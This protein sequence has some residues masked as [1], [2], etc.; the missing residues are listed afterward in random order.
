VLTF[1]KSNLLVGRDVR[2]RDS[3][4]V[5]VTDWLE[6]DPITKRKK[7]GYA[8]KRPS[9]LPRGTHLQSG[10]PDRSTYVGYSA[11]SCNVQGTPLCRGGATGR[12]SLGLRQSHPL[13]LAP[14]EGAESPAD[15]L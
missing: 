5:D 1:A 2:H 10:I 6:A 15:E 7:Q 11:D 12:S 14:L 13:F 4:S 3:H 8:P 9:L